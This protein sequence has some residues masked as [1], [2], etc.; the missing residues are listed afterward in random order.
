MARQPGSGG[1]RR[2]F[3]QKMLQ[4]TRQLAGE[5]IS[6]KLGLPGA[7]KRIIGLYELQPGKS[8]SK[9]ILRNQ[10]LRLLLKNKVVRTPAEEHCMAL[11]EAVATM[12][13][14]LSHFD[15]ERI[16]LNEGQRLH[17]AALTVLKIVKLYKPKGSVAREGFERIAGDVAESLREINAAAAQK[18]VGSMLVPLAKFE[19]IA[20]A[21]NMQIGSL[22]QSKGVEEHTKTGFE[23][24]KQI[25]REE[26]GKQASGG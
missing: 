17:N 13:F 12:Q 6:S 4:A 8:E 2:G 25:A 11:A 21:G 3:N 23:M 24:I 15:P 9:S 7:A 20:S 5:K 26:L 1:R 22:L 19:A 10:M 16:R 14:V 18:A